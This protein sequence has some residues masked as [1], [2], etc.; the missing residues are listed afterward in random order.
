MQHSLLCVFTLWQTLS[1]SCTQYM[2]S[3]HMQEGRGNIS[4]VHITVLV[5]TFLSSVRWRLGA[6][7]G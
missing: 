4:L 7:V 1:L 6:S 3:T 2:Y 5:L